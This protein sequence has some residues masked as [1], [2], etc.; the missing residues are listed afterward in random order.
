MAITSAPRNLIL[1]P[2]QI[3][4]NYRDA[5]DNSV[6]VIVFFLFVLQSENHPVFAWISSFSAK[7]KVIILRS[8]KSASRKRSGLR[9]T[10][11]AVPKR[12]TRPGTD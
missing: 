8:A 6:A 9:A 5:P 12:S 4:A 2:V 7:G 3:A 1:Q 11:G 10:N